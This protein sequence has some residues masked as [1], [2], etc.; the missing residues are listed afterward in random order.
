MVLELNGLRTLLAPAAVEEYV[1]HLPDAHDFS[2]SDGH[3]FDPGF[4]R[5]VRVN[6]A[7]RVENSVFRRL[8]GVN[9]GVK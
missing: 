1:S 7:M 8:L 3:C 5:I 2:V 4:R 9:L 6:P